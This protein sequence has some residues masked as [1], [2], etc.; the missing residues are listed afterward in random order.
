MENIHNTIDMMIDKYSDNEYVMGRLE[1]YLVVMLPNLLENADKNNN[2]RHKRKHD[3]SC[4]STDYINKFMLINKY[5][6][7]CQN[8]LF[9]L[10]DDKHFIPCSEDDIQYKILSEITNDRE[11]VPWKH[12]IKI[13]IIK[14]IKE[15]SPLNA[16]PESATIQFVI[17]L[18]YPTIFLSRNHVKYFLT[19]IGDILC[20]KISNIYIVSTCI[21]KIINELH[22]QNNTYFENVNLIN[23]IKYKYHLYEFNKCRL[24]YINKQI[25]H[26]DIPLD[27]TK[28]VVD[29]LCVAAHYSSRYTSSDIFLNQCNEKMLVDHCLFLNRNPVDTIVDNFID[30]YIEPCNK[31]T[32]TNKNMIFVWKKYL[33]EQNLPNILLHDTLLDTLKQRIEFNKEGDFFVGVTSIILPVVAEFI[34]FWDSSISENINTEYEIDEISVLFKKWTSKKFNDIDDVLILELIRHL[35]VNID[36]NIHIDE[37]KYIVNIKCNLWDKSQEVIDS[38]TFF[39]D[40][41]SQEITQDTSYN[42]K[43]LSDAYAFYVLYKKGGLIISKRYFDKVAK[44]IIKDY[45]DSDDLIKN[46]W[47]I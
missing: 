5:Y 16:I 25:V 47:F 38:L 9:M 1:N 29:I 27:F 7:C 41:Y 28:Y 42:I 26:F 17:N 32:I 34:N 2:E 24:L 3:L 19:V 11:L 37:D 40:E 31:S 15:R 33:N 8:E 23:N 22:Q 18:F 14:L 35:Y 10:Y 30:K 36:G 20:G 4:N 43:S 13:G 46:I 12:K 6:Y 44:D 39:K 45:I 21:K